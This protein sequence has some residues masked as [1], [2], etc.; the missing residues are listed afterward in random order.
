M[1]VPRCRRGSR[2]KGRERQRAIAEGDATK[3]RP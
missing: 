2:V 3:E 1:G